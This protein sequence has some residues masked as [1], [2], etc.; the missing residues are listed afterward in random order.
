MADDD[1]DRDHRV[2]AARPGGDRPFDGRHRR[3]LAAHRRRVA[4]APGG[5]GACARSAEHRQRVHGDDRAADRQPGQAGAGAARLL[6]GLHDALAE[7]RAAHHGHGDRAG[8]RRALDRP[9]LQGR[10]LEGERGLRLHQAVVPAVGALRAG[11]G[12][13]GRRAGPEDRAEGGFLCAAVRRCDEPVEFPADQPRGAAQDRRDRRREPAEGPEQPA[14][15]SRAR[16][17]QAAHQD[18]RHGGLQAGR[19]HRRLARQGGLPERPDAADPVHA[20]HREGAEAAAADRAAVDQ[21]VLHPRPAAAEQLRP[22]G[23]VAG[24]HGVRDLLGQPGR[25]ARREGLRGLHEGGLSRRAGRDRA[26]DRRAR[27]ERHRLLP[28]RHAAGEHARLHGGEEGR[29]DQD[30]RRSSSP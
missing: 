3:T 25:E 19:E 2:Q 10:R 7:H 26:G 21:Q 1:Q 12:E 8:D 14:G 18:D 13:A 4:E 22:L 28:R 16:Q 9:A 5:R 17:G 29:P 27:G 20:D 24:P 15:R 11:R 23:G 6:A 30:R